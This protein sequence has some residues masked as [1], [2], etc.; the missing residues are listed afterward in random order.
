M[1]AW[2]EA[3]KANSRAIATSILPR[4]QQQYP[5]LALNVRFALLGYRDVGDSPQFET[6]DFTDDAAV[7]EA[8]VR[9]QGGSSRTA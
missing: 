4:I 3:A 5:H 6:Q 1:S 9:A 2:L 8:K 7:L